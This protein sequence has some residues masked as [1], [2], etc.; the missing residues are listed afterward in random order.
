MPAMSE[1]SYIQVYSKYLFVLISE[2][3]SYDFSLGHMRTKT[4]QTFRTIINQ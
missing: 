4:M 3:H 1:M 2:I